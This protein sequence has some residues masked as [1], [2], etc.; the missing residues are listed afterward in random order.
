MEIINDN[1]VPREPKRGRGDSGNTGGN[2]FLGA[3]LM[4]TGLFWLLYN[5]DVL[6]YCVFDAVFSWQMLLVVIGGYLIA[7]RKYIAGGI[8]GTLGLVFVIADMFDICIS[9]SKVALPAVIIAI[10][11]AIILTKLGRK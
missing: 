3:A 11:A 7:S 1:R 2:I 8:V 6:P 4:A 10:G 9:M 5:F